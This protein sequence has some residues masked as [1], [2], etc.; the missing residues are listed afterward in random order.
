MFNPIFIVEFLRNR[1][2]LSIPYL[3][4]QGIQTPSI[5]FWSCLRFNI[6]NVTYIEIFRRIFSYFVYFYCRKQ[7]ISD[8][9]FK[10]PTE[11][12]TQYP[13]EV[14]IKSIKF[15]FLAQFLGVERDLSVRNMCHQAKVGRKSNR[16]A[17]NDPPWQILVGINVCKCLCVFAQWQS[18][19][20]SKRGI[21]LEI[22]Q[23]APLWQ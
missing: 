7:H 18:C 16:T 14:S 9:N 8:L 11:V 12:S 4:L 17:K 15:R 21:P 13:D 1:V 10:Q 6:N 3:M 19:S 20:F 22:R 5:T 23:P 2:I